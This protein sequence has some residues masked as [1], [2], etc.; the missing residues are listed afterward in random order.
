M[1]IF[2]AKSVFLSHEWYK[3]NSVCYRTRRS[4]PLTF[5]GKVLEWINELVTGIRG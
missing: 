2:Y 5:A 4:A 1:L 3:E